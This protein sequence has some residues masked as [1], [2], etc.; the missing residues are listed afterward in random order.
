MW[1]GRLFVLDK[2][3]ENAIRMFSKDFIG[4]N[5]LQS[6]SSNSKGN[7]LFFLRSV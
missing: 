7:G 1:L 6:K 4:V 2:V 3:N 5:I